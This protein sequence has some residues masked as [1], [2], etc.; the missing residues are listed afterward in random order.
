MKPSNLTR[1]IIRA[2]VND[3]PYTIRGCELHRP[4]VQRCRS[5]Q[6]R[7]AFTQKRNFF[8]LGG[9]IQ[10]SQSIFQNAKPTS[11]NLE[12]AL[13][14]L[15]DL[16]KARRSNSRFPPENEIVDAFRSIFASRLKSP[17][18]L[19]RNEVNL[20]TE[21]FIHLQERSHLL[22]GDG[23]TALLEDDLNNVMLALASSTGRDRYRS[24][25][26]VLATYIFEALRDPSTHPEE[27]LSKLGKQQVRGSL[28]ATYITVLS[29]TG[30]AQDALDLLRK[31]WGS[32][33]RTS[34]PI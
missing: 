32:L 11:P 23:K 22:T 28:L 3:R 1:S 8:G 13:G 26:R 33:E 5:I 4:R 6:P 27:Y 12:R 21:A 15:S 10:T 18:H 34:L 9:A 30:S 17:R 2:I 16:V 14:K 20:A 29:K 7:H 25:A 19:T 24:D 31:S